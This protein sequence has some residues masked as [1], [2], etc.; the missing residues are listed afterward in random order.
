MATTD[1][2]ELVTI[3]S[4]EG[5]EMQ[6]S[7]GRA[8]QLLERKGYRKSAPTPSKKTAAKRAAKKATPGRRGAAKKVAEAP[9]GG[10]A[11]AL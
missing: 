5:V 4:A 6:V 8:M 2:D 7:P 3:Y 1:R 9:A 11:A 10:D